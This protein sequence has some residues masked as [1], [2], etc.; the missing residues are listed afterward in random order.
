MEI[1]IQMASTNA[2]I[3]Q[4]RGLCRQWLDLH[5]Q[6]FPTDWP[7]SGKG[8]EPDHFNA[9]LEN[10]SELHSRPRGAIFLAL[11][12]DQSV[13]CVMYGEASP[14]VAEFNRMFVNE[15][16]RGRGI[17]RLLLDRMIDQMIQ[18]GYGKVV[19]SSANFLKHAKAM[20]QAAGFVDVPHPERFPSEWKPYIYF[21]ER[22][23][24][25]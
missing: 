9:V 3:D 17:G 18:D 16:G 23:L 24:T 25:E 19:F 10:L 5:W 21:L 4:V 7:T 2:E 6:N 13:G 1:S 22:S 20:Y 15:A 12:G 8:M 14:G 11:L